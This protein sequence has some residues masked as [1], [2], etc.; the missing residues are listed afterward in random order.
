MYCEDRDAT[1]AAEVV[2]GETQ[3]K[4]KETAGKCSCNAGGE[5]VE[6]KGESEWATQGRRG[7]S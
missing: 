5:P 7:A 6:A 3:Q 4:G 2:Q 1:G